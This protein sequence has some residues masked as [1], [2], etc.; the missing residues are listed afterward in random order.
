MARALPYRFSPVISNGG[1]G[2]YASGGTPEMFCGQKCRSAPL[3][4]L[5][6]KNHCSIVNTVFPVIICP[7]GYG[8]ELQNPIPAPGFSRHELQIFPDI[9]K[10]AAYLQYCG[11]P[12][13][14]RAFGMLRAVCFHAPAGGIKIIFLYI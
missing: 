8:R 2:I 3:S 1:S 7:A 9:F 12:L 6:R 5:C 10:S 14:A 4:V 13:A 11:F